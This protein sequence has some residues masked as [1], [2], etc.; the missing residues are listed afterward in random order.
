MDKK[1]WYIYAMGNI[2]INLAHKKDQNSDI[3]REVDGPIHCHTEWSKLEKNII[4]YHLY[5]E[6]RKMVQI[7]LFANKK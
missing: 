4:K 5:V 7:N 2:N 3:C 6:S 1:T